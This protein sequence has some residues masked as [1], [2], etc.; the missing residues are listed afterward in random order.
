MKQVICDICGNIIKGKYTL[1]NFPTMFSGNI[2]Q[3]LDEDM[4]DDVC[5]K[6]AS[7]LYELIEKF[8]KDKKTTEMGQKN[9]QT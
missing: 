5:Q 6:C 2:I 8:K 9:E 1:I 7:E 4:A 3:N